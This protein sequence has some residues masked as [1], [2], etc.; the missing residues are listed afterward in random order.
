MG[1]PS[2]VFGL[3]Q[4]FPGIRSP[5][6]LLSDVGRGYSPMTG[7]G[8]AGGGTGVRV[9]AGAPVPRKIEIA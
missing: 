5:E 9:S 8:A 3:V 6:S 7:G 4:R 2:A 1:T